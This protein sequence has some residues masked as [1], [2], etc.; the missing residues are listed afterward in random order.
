MSGRRRALAV[1]VECACEC[2]FVCMCAYVCVCLSICV[3]VCVCVCVCVCL[4]VRVFVCVRVWRICWHRPPEAYD[5]LRNRVNL[6]AT[7][8]SECTDGVEV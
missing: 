4:R 7:K 6:I 1:L 5:I 2:V 8:D 3:R